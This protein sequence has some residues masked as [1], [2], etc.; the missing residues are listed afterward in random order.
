MENKSDLDRYVAFFCP[1]TFAHLA[2]LAAARV[3]SL[4][5]D[6][7]SNRTFRFRQCYNVRRS[8]RRPDRLFAFQFGSNILADGERRFFRLPE[9]RSRGHRNHTV[10]PP[11]QGTNDAGASHGFGSKASGEWR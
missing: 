5:G 6:S 10:D 3:P 9:D 4:V 2:R 7:A 8:C 11:F 1:F